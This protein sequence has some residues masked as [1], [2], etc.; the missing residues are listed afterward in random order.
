MRVLREEAFTSC[1]C[2]KGLH[3]MDFTCSLSYKFV[4]K[5]VYSKFTSQYVIFFTLQDLNLARLRL[6][7]NPSNL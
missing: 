1:P 5:L 3:C 6:W 2:I 4:Q 7:L